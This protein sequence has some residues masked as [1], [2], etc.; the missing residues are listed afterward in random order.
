MIWALSILCTISICECFIRLPLAGC[1]KDFSRYSSKAYRTVSSSRI[2]DHWKEKVLAIYAVKIF[3]LSWQLLLLLVL[4]LL[5]LL[6]WHWLGNL[7]GLDLLTYAAGPSGILLM[8]VSAVVYLYV[9][10][11]IF[12][13]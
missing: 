9:R 8:T 4:A 10:N 2:S 6:L 1:I 5:P 13:D 12:H 7:I 3:F 11:K